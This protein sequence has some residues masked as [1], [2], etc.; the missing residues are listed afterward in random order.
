MGKM[1]PCTGCRYFR[2]MGRTGSGKQNRC[3]HYMLDEGRLRPCPPGAECVVRVVGAED[4]YKIEQMRR[5]WA[6]EGM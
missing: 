1:N 3:C 2:K 6:H 5:R 4:E